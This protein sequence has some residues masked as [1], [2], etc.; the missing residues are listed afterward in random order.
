[1]SESSAAEFR[2]FARMLPSQ[3]LVGPKVATCTLATEVPDIGFDATEQARDD[4]C[5]D[6]LP[7]VL[8]VGSHEPRKNHVTVLVAA[9]RLWRAGHAFHLVFIGGSGWHSEAFDRLLLDLQAK[10]RPVQ[11]IKRAAEETLWAAYRLARFTVFP[12]LTEGYGLPAAES[13]A[14][15]TPL[16]TSS[17]GSM[18][19][20]AAGGGAMV[21]DPRDPSDLEAAMARLLTDDS[22]LETLRHQ[23]AGRRWKT[24]DEYAHETWNYLA[25]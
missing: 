15:G 3:G 11:V 12:S 22:S 6:S 1:V 9:E 18:A 2:N 5:L 21:V 4:L 14:A 17:F 23:A 25:T 20:I 16:I 19:E 7:L 8:V 24:W 10:D 13:L